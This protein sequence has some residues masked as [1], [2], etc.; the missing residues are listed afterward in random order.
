MST[1]VWAECNEGE[2]ELWPDSP[3]GGCFDIETTTSLQF[4]SIGLTGEIPPEIGQLINLTLLDLGGNQLTGSIPSE[5][6]NLTNLTTLKLYYNQ[7]T[8]P[9]PSEIGNLTNLTTLHLYG[10]QLSGDFFTAI[11]PLTNL[12]YL[13]FYSNQFTGSIPPEIGQLT[14]LISLNLAV[15]QLTGP[16]PSEISNLTNLN[17][18]YLYG[19][20]LSGV[21][22]S[23]IC[24]LELIDLQLAENQLCD[25][26]PACVSED[27]IIFQDTTN[28]SESNC[29]EGEVELWDI[30]YD[31]ATTTELFLSSQNLTGEIPVEIGDLVNLDVLWLNDNQLTGAIPSSL[32]NLTG[33]YNLDLSNNSLIGEIPTWL[34]NSFQQLKKLNLSMN[35]FNSGTMPIELTT[36]PNLEYLNLSSTALSGSIPPEIGV[37]QNLQSLALS[38]NNLS[39]EIPPELGELLLWSLDL[40]HNN[41]TG[42]IPI[43]ID[44]I[45]YMSSLDL[46]HNNLSGEI[47]ENLFSNPYTYNEIYGSYD[48]IWMQQLDL[49]Y[50]QLS[51]ELTNTMFEYLTCVDNDFYGSCG[52]NDHEYFYINNNQLSGVLPDNICRLNCSM[53]FSLADNAFC[54]PYPEDCADYLSAGYSSWEDVIGN[55]DT[56]DCSDLSFENLDIP[57]QYKVSNVYPN[58]FNPSTNITYEVPQYSMID[59]YIYDLNGKLVDILISEYQ[60]AG[61]YTITWDGSDYPS[62]LYILSMQSNNFSHSQKIS[63]TK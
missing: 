6:G 22:P 40:S 46:S 62:G 5:L 57:N 39:G 43:E 12:E 10:N 53:F 44:A 54:E 26:Y 63:L 1:F 21:I 42:S 24:D 11:A 60:Q 19:N 45:P 23:E 52:C 50:N 47:P 51:G 55:Q 25:P 48:R 29:A 3:Y 56:S 16:I 30:C 61:I 28:C 35:N 4:P 38:G 32:S 8:G 17:N 14:N 37:L 49:S 27:D 13:N 2:V 31:I 36:I 41:L 18:L 15:N 20:Q 59:I 58:P 33:L 34:D 7:L 9:I